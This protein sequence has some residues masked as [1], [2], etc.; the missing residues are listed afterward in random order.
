[1]ISSGMS[2]LK[3]AAFLAPLAWWTG[4]GG[5]V[6]PKLAVFACAVALTAAEAPR[7]YRT[8]LDFPV[9]LGLMASCLAALASDF[10]ELG[11]YGWVN[12]HAYG[13]VAMLGY[14]WLAKVAAT[15]E[16]EVERVKDLAVAG[17][18]ICA[19]VGL[20][21]LAGWHLGLFPWLPGGRAVGAI[22]GP[23][24]FGAY[25]A[26]VLPLARGRQAA[27]IGAGIVASGSRAAWLACA[28]YPVYL[29]WSA[30]RT[31]RGIVLI[32]PRPNRLILA[33]V[34]AVAFLAA[35]SVFNRPLGQSDSG[36]IEAMRAG[37]DAARTWPWT[38]VGPSAFCVAA[39]SQGKGMEHRHTHNDLI[40]AAATTGSIGLVAYLWAVLAALR[41][42]KQDPAC[43]AGLAALFIAAKFNPLS[44]EHF[45]LG[46]I[47]A[48]FLCR[49]RY[50]D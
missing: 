24:Y 44:V 40:E 3:L 31:D 6:W 32:L 8:R 21:Q 28:V 25:L 26:A 7:W 37:L 12:D 11:L 43:A 27:L 41:G 4:Q 23:T 42:W 39:P 16:D 36:R 46:S 13:I 45:M 14:A 2:G 9:W 10:P 18:A 1:M 38:G 47:M 48:G 50:D 19:A 22:G 49:K 15:A 20:A 30:R 35:H 29:A 5:F 33:L 34:A 17:G